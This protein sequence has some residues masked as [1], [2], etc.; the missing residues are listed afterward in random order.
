MTFRW[1]STGQG[2]DDSQ[3]ESRQGQ[4]QEKRDVISPRKEQ[5]SVIQRL[6]R[7]LTPLLVFALV[8]TSCNQGMPPSDGEFQLKSDTL[9]FDGSQYEFAWVGADGQ[10]N[11]ARGN[12]VKL[13]Q[14]ERTYL[15]VENGKPTIHLKPDQAVAVKY[16]DN[17][18]SYSN[19][20]FPF[21]VGTAI[22]NSMGG[23][24]TVI[25]S[26]PNPGT[27]SVPPSQP[28]YRYPPTN[29]SA[30]GE[31]LQG[32]V[33]NDKPAAPDYKKINPNPNAA[34]GQ[35]GG[36][37]SGVGATNKSPSTSSGQVGGTGSGD[38]ATGKG[39]DAAS[40][41]SGGTGVGSGATNK[42]PSTSGA[43]SSGGFSGAKSTGG[44]KGG[45]RR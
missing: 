23:N 32:T 30:R 9:T 12:D 1:F 33:S 22:G 4:R 26:Q 16:Q 45:K 40:G 21:L 15:K 29:S 2:H 38:A 20:W 35:T 25:V 17:N 6:Y 27:S 8:L 13:V 43:K 10:V 28:A 37:G 14:D 18:G 44:F 3:A 42:Q 31:S 19:P 39:K 36:T 41:Q 5:M 11:W 34:S 7:L 24:R